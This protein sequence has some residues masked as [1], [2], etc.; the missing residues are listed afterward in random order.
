MMVKK[1]EKRGKAQ[2]DGKEERRQVEGCM[3]LER[4]SCAGK[5]QAASGLELECEEWPSVASLDT[6]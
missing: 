2:A 1:G 5:L 4:A 6:L 3:R